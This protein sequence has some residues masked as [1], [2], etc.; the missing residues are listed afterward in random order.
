MVCQ[1]CGFPFLNLPDSILTDLPNSIVLDA[2]SIPTYVDLFRGSF[3]RNGMTACLFA[4]ERFV[5]V[6]RRLR[7]TGVEFTEVEVR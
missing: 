2:T 4:T 1:S 6:T 5:E 7:L 3:E